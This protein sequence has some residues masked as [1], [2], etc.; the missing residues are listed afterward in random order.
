MFWSPLVGHVV[1]VLA[2]R[3]MEQ[4]PR[5][6]PKQGMDPEPWVDFGVHGTCQLKNGPS[7]G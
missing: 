1:R 6:R 5:R 2:H 3:G 4:P 7:V